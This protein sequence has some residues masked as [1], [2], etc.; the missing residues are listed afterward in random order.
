VFKR[1]VKGYFGKRDNLFRAIKNSGDRVV[2]VQVVCQSK[3][4]NRWK[5]NVLRS[6][7]V[8]GIVKMSMNA[9]GRRKKEEDFL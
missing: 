5:W 1:G 3:K 9:L 8:H 7:G 4:V 6:G 2:Q